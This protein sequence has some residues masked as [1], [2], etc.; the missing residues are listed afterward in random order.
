MVGIG[1]LFPLES[2]D[3]GIQ[4]STSWDDALIIARAAATDPSKLQQRAQQC[5]PKSL[6]LYA[7]A[8]AAARSVVEK[9][10]K[11]VHRCQQLSGGRR[12]GAVPCRS[13]W[14]VS[15]GIDNLGNRAYWAFHPYPQRTFNAEIRYVL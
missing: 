3:S 6:R 15:A 4:T 7:D 5:L 13:A 10:E 12:A 2:L 11:G 8:G 9:V 14:K 1:Y